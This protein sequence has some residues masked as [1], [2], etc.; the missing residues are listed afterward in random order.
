MKKTTAVLLLLFALIFQNVNAQT[1]ADSSLLKK[2]FI[3][4][5]EALKEPQNVFR[6]NLSNQTIQFPDSIWSK[7]TN[8]QY[9][10]L[11]NDHL[12]NIPSGIGNLKT[13]TVLDLSGN[14]FKEL[15]SSFTGLSNLRELYLNDEKN[16]QFDQSIPVLSKLPNL[17]SLHLEGDGLKKLPKNIFQLTTL[18]SLYINNNRFTEMPL[19]INGLKNLKYLDMHDNKL[20]IPN[21]VN[22]D[23]GFGVKIRF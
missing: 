5:E 16:F 18:E 11:K 22:Q 2:E 4:L 19:E 12:K 9:L 3:S 17:K 8:L 21:Q 15:P 1:P 20:K 13:L 23:S 14:D 7:F 6:L 10:S